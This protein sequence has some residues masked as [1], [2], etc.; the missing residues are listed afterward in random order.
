MFFSEAHFKHSPGAVCG[1]SG[2]VFLSACIFHSASDL[3]PAG[4][5]A[6]H[7]NLNV[8]GF[9]PS[10][11]P[12]GAGIQTDTGDLIRVREA[13]HIHIILSHGMERKKKCLGKQIA[14]NVHRNADTN[15]LVCKAPF[16]AFVRLGG[17]P[18]KR[19]TQWHNDIEKRGIVYRMKEERRREE[20][21]G[22]TLIQLAALARSNYL[23]SP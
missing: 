15:T 3:S 7:L 10:N 12:H 18:L 17:G 4:R 2:H 11:F 9:Y 19:A 20:R 13:N 6:A 16:V 1:C 8:R 21:K 22:C 14:I 5:Q 23:Y